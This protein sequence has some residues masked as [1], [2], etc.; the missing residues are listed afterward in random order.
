MGEEFPLCAL[1][2][3]GGG[4][5]FIYP[6]RGNNCMITYYLNLDDYLT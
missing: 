3:D 4:G 2:S 5:A 6:L 1:H